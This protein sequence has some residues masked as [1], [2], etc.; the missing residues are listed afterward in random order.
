MR[1]LASEADLQYLGSD[2]FPEKPRVAKPSG[3]TVEEKAFYFCLD[4]IQL[5]EDIYFEL[6][7]SDKGNRFN[8]KYAGWIEVFNAWARS[9]DVWRAWRFS[10][11]TYNKLFQEFLDEFI[12]KAKKERRKEEFPD[13]LRHL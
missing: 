1:R 5:M 4:A 10:K 12:D 2:F 6:E 7:L 9:E 3:Q 8:P 13:E 11:K